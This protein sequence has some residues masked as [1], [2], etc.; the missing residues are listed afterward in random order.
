MPECWLAINADDVGDSVTCDACGQTFAAKPDAKPDAEPEAPEPPEGYR[1]LADDERIVFGDLVAYDSEA[2]VDACGSIGDRVNTDSARIAIRPIEPEPESPTWNCGCTSG[3]PAS[4]SRCPRCKDERPTPKAPAAPVMDGYA[5]VALTQE[6]ECLWI[7]DPRNRLNIP[8]GELE[9]L[10]VGGL[11]FLLPN[12][13]WQIHCDGAPL[14]FSD[15]SGLHLTYYPG[16]VVVR[17]AFVMLAA[18]DAAQ[19]EG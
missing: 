18:A 16:D 8:L 9:P 3:L 13:E 15:G 11:A 7:D 4:L 10:R 19:G 12:G 14:K 17:P 6:D 1:L 5:A 2:F